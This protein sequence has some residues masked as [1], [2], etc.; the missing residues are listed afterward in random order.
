MCFIVFFWGVPLLWI[1]TQK[2]SYL[3]TVK[4][5]CVIVHWSLCLITLRSKARDMTLD[6]QI[7][8]EVR[9]F[10]YV[11]GVHILS[12]QEVGFWMSRVMMSYLEGNKPQQHPP[13]LNVF[14]E[15]FVKLSSIQ[16]PKNSIKQAPSWFMTQ[17]QPTLKNQPTRVVFKLPGINPFVSHDLPITCCFLPGLFGQKPPTNLHLSTVKNRRLI[18]GHQVPNKGRPDGDQWEIRLPVEMVQPFFFEKVNLFTHLITFGTSEI[19][20]AEKIS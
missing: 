8:P 12:P 15:T 6:I 9:R 1:T 17:Q 3:R 4:R 16:K 7:R 20:I 11:L 13:L 18:V 19:Y 14:V 10:S 2:Y 5:S